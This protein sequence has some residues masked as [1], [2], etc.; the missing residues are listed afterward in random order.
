MA[1]GRGL[2]G[3]LAILG[4]ALIF[5]SRRKVTAASFVSPFDFT[6]EPSPIT[7]AEYYYYMTKPAAEVDPDQGEELRELTTTGGKTGLVLTV[8]GRIPTP[9][10]TTIPWP[11]KRTG[12][13]AVEEQLQPLETK[14]EESFQDIEV[15]GRVI[16]SVNLR[17]QPL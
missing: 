17:L 15:N 10:G 12:R 16:K 5:G 9:S 14:Q 8:N 2:G 11:T 1:R 4:L 6:R 7:R 13:I 3:L